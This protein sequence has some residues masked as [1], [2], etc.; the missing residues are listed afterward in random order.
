MMMRALG[1][2]RVDVAE[3]LYEKFGDSLNLMYKSKARCDFG[4]PRQCRMHQNS[5]I[6]WKTLR[7]AFVSA[8]IKFF[9][10]GREMGRST[11]L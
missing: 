8:M 6:R 7:S 5:R 9:F 1:Y 2:G 3:L 10:V 4:R 11:P